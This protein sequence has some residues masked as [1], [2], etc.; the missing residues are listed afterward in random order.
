MNSILVII[1][2]EDQKRVFSFPSNL[3]E[4]ECFDK[5]KHSIEVGI[6]R[7]FFFPNSKVSAKEYEEYYYLKNGEFVINSRFVLETKI[8]EKIRLQRDNFLKAL[9]VPF[10]ISLETED[11]VLKNHI[12][13][14]K[15]F[16]R[17]VPN[18][19][20]LS[21]IEDEENLKKFTPFQNIFTAAIADCGSGY[22]KPPT[23][24][25]EEPNP[26]GYYGR[27]AEVT[28]TIKDGKLSNLFITDNG[29]GYISQPSVC[30]SPPDE[31]NGKNAIV[32]AGNPENVISNLN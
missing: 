1:D 17:D 4:Q 30:V 32:V 9:D 11:E 7:Q 20:N 23:I 28:A 15:N 3:S 8:Q 6:K 14:L 5:I 27:K 10:M 2:G 25:F 24:S 22:T 26:N 18:K 29:C 13:N 12:I 16:L 21:T 31:P 19:L